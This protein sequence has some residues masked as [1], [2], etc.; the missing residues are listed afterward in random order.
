M[1]KRGSQVGGLFI[2]AGICSE[3]MLP[4]LAAPLLL[5]LVSPH[6]TSNWLPYSNALITPSAPAHGHT[7]LPRGH[8]EES[9]VCTSRARP[10]CQRTCLSRMT[11]LPG[12]CELMPRSVLSESLGSSKKERSL[13]RKGIGRSTSLFMCGA[14][15]VLECRSI[16]REDLDEVLDVDR[17]SY[18]KQGLWTRGMYV[19]EMESERSRTLVLASREEG[20]LGVGCLSFLFDEGSIVN[21]AIRPLARGRGRASRNISSCTFSF[22]VATGAASCFS[23]VRLAGPQTSLFLE[24]HSFS[25]CSPH[26]SMSVSVSPR[27]TTTLPAP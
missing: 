6:Q 19:E 10:T 8:G 24:F 13:Y 23:S 11:R 16:K 20:I 5:S 18:G 2:F 15:A 17:E 1:A 9:S 26:P 25:V 27:Y 14:A 22:S 7:H 21:L 4:A 3:K 12:A